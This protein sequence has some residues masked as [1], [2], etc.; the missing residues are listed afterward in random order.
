MNKRSVV[1]CV[2]V[3]IVIY[4]MLLSISSLFGYSEWSDNITI[5]R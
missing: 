1:V 2:G 4:G 5:L 3:S